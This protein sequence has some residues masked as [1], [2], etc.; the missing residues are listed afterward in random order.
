MG[1][2]HLLLILQNVD[3]NYDADTFLLLFAKTQELTKAEAYT[4]RVGE[5]DV[6]FKDMAYRVVADY[7][8]TLCF[9]I[10]DGATPSN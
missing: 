10:S 5:E 7:I 8:R 9:A 3:S 2:E 6:G 1:L 4:G